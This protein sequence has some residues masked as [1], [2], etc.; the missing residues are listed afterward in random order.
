MYEK[1][2]LYTSLALNLLRPTD[3][4]L[5]DVHNVYQL[6]RPDFLTTVHKYSNLDLHQIMEYG[7]SFGLMTY[8]RKYSDIAMRTLGMRRGNADE[9]WGSRRSDAALALARNTEER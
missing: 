9:D 1:P 6:S 2:T 8:G 7:K 4:G 5:T 3:P